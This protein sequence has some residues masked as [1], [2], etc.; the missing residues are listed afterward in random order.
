[1]SSY[2]LN[3]WKI[4]VYIYIYKYKIKW[5]KYYEFLPLILTEHIKAPDN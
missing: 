4:I 2:M 5:L 1:M 3:T